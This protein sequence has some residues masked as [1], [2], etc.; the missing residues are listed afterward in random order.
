MIIQL[1][2]LSGSGKS[3]IVRKVLDSFILAPH[4]FISG[5]IFGAMGLNKPEAYL[6][7]GGPITTPLYILGP[8]HISHEGVDRLTKRMSFAQFIELLDGYASKG[9]VLFESLRFSARWAEPT[10]GRWLFQ[11][12][13][14]CLL[15]ILQVP[16]EEVQASIAQR[17][18][19]LGREVK[20]QKYADAERKMFDNATDYAREVGM[21]IEE[22][23]RDNAVEKIIGWLQD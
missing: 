19:D 6:C 15:A 8:Y 9:N 11:N 10:M 21:R 12:K 18:R 1:R 22:V 5:T 2:G 7:R 4:S 16:Y 23:T 13:H 17:Q 14:R 3:T 20:E